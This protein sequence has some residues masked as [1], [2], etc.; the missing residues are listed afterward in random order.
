MNHMTLCTLMDIAALLS[1]GPVVTEAG[2]LY[3]NRFSGSWYHRFQ[4]SG[5]FYDANGPQ[6]TME[7]VKRVIPEGTS[8]LL[9]LY[10]PER[11]DAFVDWMEA[12]GA[13][14]VNPQTAMQ[15]DLSRITRPENSPA[16]VI[17]RKN[18]QEWADCC[19]ASFRKQDEYACFAQ[20]YGHCRFYGVMQGGRITSTL[21]LNLVDGCAGLHEVGT[22]PEFRGRGQAGALVHQALWDAREAGCTVGVLQA[23]ARGYPLYRRFGFTDCGVLYNFR[24]KHTP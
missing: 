4:I 20:M 22:R 12:H 9:S 21:M 18:L 5:S 10:Q 11:D 23:S 15:Y 2:T 1:D 16:T 17:S 24:W 3:Q 8:P 13:V 19:A 7:A 14:L 6:K